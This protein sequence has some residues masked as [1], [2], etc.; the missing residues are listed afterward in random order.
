MKNWIA[1]LLILCLAFAAN[2]CFAQEQSPTKNV[3]FISIDDLNDWEGA[4]GHQ[5]AITPNMDK[6][7]E[8]GVLFTN[9]HASQAVCTASRNSILSGV[10]PSSSGWYGSIADMRK[11]Y[12]QVM[13]DHR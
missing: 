2:V 13:G 1:V 9:A 4:L 5:Q 10:H 11:S 7:F 3:L 12:D 8:T 6:L